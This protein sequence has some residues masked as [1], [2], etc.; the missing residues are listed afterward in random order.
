MYKNIFLVHT[1][2][3]DN[4]YIPNGNDLIDKKKWTQH[5]DIPIF[6]DSTGW[7]ETHLNDDH[8]NDERKFFVNHVTP[9]KVTDDDLHFFAISN[10]SL[11]YRDMN[12]ECFSI[13]EKII[14]LTNINKNFYILFL[15]EHES[16]EESSFVE[17]NNKL[18]KIGVNT[19]KVIFITNN[20][21]I[22]DIKEKNNLDCIVYKTFFINFS[23][24]KVFR[25]CGSDYLKDKSSKLFISRNRGNRMHRSMLIFEIFKNKWHD[26]INYSWLNKDSDTGNYSWFEYLYGKNDLDKYSSL[27]DKVNSHYKECDYE[28]NKNLIDKETKEFT[29]HDT[30][31]PLFFI[32]EVKEAFE[33][34]YFN[35]VTE[36]LFDVDD[37]IHITE[38][39]LR[40]F[41]FYQFPIIMAS[42]GHIKKLKEM[43]NFDMFD[44]IIDHSY[45]SETDHKV[46]YHM[47][48][49]EIQKIIDNKDFYIDFYKNNKFRFSLNKEKLHKFGWYSKTMDIDFFWNLCD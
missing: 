22:Y 41:H 30:F 27:L 45:D 9:E 40:P 42:P 16:D 21:K 14:K 2:W 31:P 38:K 4:M 6:S 33:N 29:N 26:F 36:T 43:Y 10:G 39:S 23:S 12:E 28:N 7:F 18:K 8:G 17:F 49:K 47:I 15:R 19:T 25:Y 13:P 37:R 34:T 20:S 35:L 24:T 44:D 32:P 3:N 48:M 5:R 46:R 11:D 1:M